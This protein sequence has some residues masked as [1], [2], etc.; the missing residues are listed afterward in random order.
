MTDRLYSISRTTTVLSKDMN[1][2]GEPNPG[3][4]VVRAPRHRGLK[5]NRTT[6]AAR[7]KLS[8]DT[9]PCKPVP[10]AIPKLWTSIEKRERIA[11]HRIC[12]CTSAEHS[13]DGNAA[14]GAGNDTAANARIHASEGSK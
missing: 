11:G 3:S 6:S 2:A 13:S 5:T 10:T 4:N 9:W 1:R 12:A 14:T 8:D 7:P